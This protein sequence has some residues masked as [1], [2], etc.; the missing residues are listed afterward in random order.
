MPSALKKA[1]HLLQAARG[2]K[3]SRNER[4]EKTL[5]LTALL[6]EAAHHEKTHKEKKREKW[7]SRMMQDPKGRIFMTAMVDQC[8]RCD[9]AKRTAD[10]LIYLIKKFGVPNFLNNIDYL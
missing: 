4:V 9:S 7:L 10:Q 5:E 6:V 1:D 2:K 3:I 8:F